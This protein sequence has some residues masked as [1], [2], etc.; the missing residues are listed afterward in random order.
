MQCGVLAQLQLSD[1]SAPWI[2]KVVTVFRVQGGGILAHSSSRRIEGMNVISSHATGT[3]PA[4]NAAMR[5]GLQRLSTGRTSDHR[6]RVPMAF[7]GAEPHR[8]QLSSTQRTSCHTRAPAEVE[9]PPE[10]KSKQRKGKEKRERAVPTLCT[11]R[12]HSTRGSRRVF[13][14]ARAQQRGGAHAP[15]ARLARPR[16]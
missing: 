2:L 7:G 1:G 6:R 9:V 10:L 14:F 4:P 11:N 16:A 12:G 3:R 13:C 5:D 8:F 15:E